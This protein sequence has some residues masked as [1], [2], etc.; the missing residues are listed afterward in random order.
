MVSERKKTYILPFKVPASELLLSPHTG[1]RSEKIFIC[2]NSMSYFS[3]FEDF[4]LHLFNSE[5]FS[6]V[7]IPA[8]R[9][10]LRTLLCN[11]SMILNDLHSSPGLNIFG[12]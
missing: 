6:P 10:R 9:P 5:G 12:F 7:V 4:R 8:S 1:G 2:E 11:E 3:T